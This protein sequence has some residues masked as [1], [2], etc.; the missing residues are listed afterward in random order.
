KTEL[1]SLQIGQ[2]P[3]GPRQGALDIADRFHIVGKR[4]VV[5]MTHIDAE[6]VDTRFAQAADQV[7]CLR[8]RTKRCDDFHTTASAHALSITYWA[9]S[10]RRVRRLWVSVGVRVHI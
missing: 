1:G 10:T 4:R 3:N 9:H 5:G 2:N 6:D 8:S 7:W